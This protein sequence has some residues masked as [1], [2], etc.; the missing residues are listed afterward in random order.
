M[1]VDTDYGQDQGSSSPNRLGLGLAGIAVVSSILASTCCVVPLI[2]VLLGVTGAWMVNLTALE[3]WTPV[4]S[5]LAVTALAG[6]GYLVFRPVAP[7]ASPEQAC[8]LPRSEVTR[9]LYMVAA[10][11]VLGL[12]LFPVAAPIFY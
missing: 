12:L 8:E 4:F 11:I 7:C 3:P 1:A 5:V 6:S 10:V 9:K 2:L